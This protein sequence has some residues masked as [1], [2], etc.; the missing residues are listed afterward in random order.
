MTRR[1]LAITSLALASFTSAS[2]GQKQLEE[3]RNVFQE[4]VESRQKIAD[5]QALWL[6]QKQTLLD[7]IELL[8]LEIELLGLRIEA[9]EADSTQAERDRIQLNAKIEELKEASAVVASVIRSL[10][11][12]ILKL[13]NAL[14]SDL[15]GKLDR[16][17]NRI[18]DRNTPQN[19]I[20]ASL[21]ERMQNIVGL[22]NQLEVF[23]NGIH[24][25]TEVRKIG[26][27]NITIQV[28]YIGLAQAYYVNK[29]Q[30][31]A[32]YG[33]VSTESGWV[34]TE[35]LTLADSILK[36]IKVYENAIP[37]EFVVLPAGK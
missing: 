24:V 30:G 28:L 35:D 26:G 3:T 2:W 13:V 4:L 19:R 33:T 17:I 5:E 29:D 37:A 15:K 7:T 36:S 1:L 23:N 10:E 16:L 25:A 11:E 31:V 8:N 32:G 9:T 20:R 22:L 18:P 12:R 21:G 34:W 6:V 27:Q 14:P